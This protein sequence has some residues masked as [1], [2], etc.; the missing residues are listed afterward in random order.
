MK[1]LITQ[2]AYILFIALL[3]LNAQESNAQD[4]TKEKTLTATFKGLNVSDNF[5]FEFNDG[6]AIVFHD[7]AISSPSKISLFDEGLVGESFTVS[8]KWVDV[9]LFNNGI[10]T[11]ETMK[12]K[13]ITN[14]TPAN[15]PY[16]RTDILVT[17]NDQ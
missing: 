4:V 16:K 15:N 3:S 14:I 1:K 7:E 12:V 10:A 17:S 6:K 2:T 9:M 5:K 8:Y 13:R 11:G